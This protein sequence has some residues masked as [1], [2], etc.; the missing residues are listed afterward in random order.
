VRRVVQAGEEVASRKLDDRRQPSR[1]GWQFVP[2]R[3]M[4]AI[5]FGGACG[6][7]EFLCPVSF[8]L[9]TTNQEQVSGPRPVVRSSNDPRRMLGSLGSFRSCSGDD[10]DVAVRELDDA[11]G[12]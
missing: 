6:S 1:R 7:Q 2:N 12:H 4:D 11:N 5:G 3:P 8:S 9:P 10:E